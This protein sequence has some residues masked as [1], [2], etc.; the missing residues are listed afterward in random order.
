MIPALPPWAGIHP[1]LVHFPIALL[2]TLP[3]F[4]GLTL[5]MGRRHR[6][7]AFAALIMLFLGTAGVFA[8]AASGEAAGKLAE[9][10]PEINAVLERHEHLAEAARGVFSG[11]TLAFAALVFIPM[12]LKREL[13]RWAHGSAHALFLAVFLGSLGFLAQIAHQGGRLVHQHGVHAL[14]APG[15]APIATLERHD[16]D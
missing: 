9:R 11:L 4:L 3:V 10:S 2:F 5:V 7:W 14:M 13:P 1:L 12:A 16:E 8:A 6:V 15:D